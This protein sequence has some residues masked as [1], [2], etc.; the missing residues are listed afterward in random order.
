MI[1]IPMSPFLTPNPISLFK[2]R[3]YPMSPIL[4]TYSMYYPMS[5]ILPTYSMYFLSSYPMCSLSHFPYLTTCLSHTGIL[6]LNVPY[7]KS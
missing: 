5:P 7:L 6:Y 3:Y 4:P 2:L 1:V